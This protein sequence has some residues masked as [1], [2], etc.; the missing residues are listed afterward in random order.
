MPS[1]T[2]FAH[3]FVS[4]YVALEGKLWG[5]FTRLLFRPGALT[6]EYLAG[7]RRRYVEPL[8]LYLTLSILFFALIRISG[9]QIFSTTSDAQPPVAASAAGGHSA[10]PG[11]DDDDRLAIGGALSPAVKRW[12]PGVQHAVERFDAMSSTEK[13]AALKNGF[14]RYAPYA[15]FCLMPVF[16]L[17]LKGLYLGT[18]RRYGEHLL[19]ALHT[20]AFAF[21]MFTA[22]AAM[23]DGLVKFLLFCWLLGYLPWAMQ[24][25]Y[26]KGV[27][28]TAWRWIVLVALHVLSLAAAILAAVF[29]GVALAS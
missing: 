10:T 2:E 5:T 26:R 13:G 24:R 25:V 4:H 19:F 12:A 15:M 3:E 20:N 18:G 9:V 23:P 14:F 11:S 21:V 27:F 1:F 17:Y 28:G 6:N 22:F 7:R 29:L 16:A 8:R